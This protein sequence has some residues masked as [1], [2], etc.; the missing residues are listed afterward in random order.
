MA[1]RVII[2]DDDEFVSTSLKTILSAQDDI[3]VLG[4]A[5]NGPEAVELFQKEKPD[6]LLSDIQMPGGDGLEAAE[7]ILATDPEARIV[8]LT[9]FADDEYILRALKLG[10]KGYLIKQ[11]VG[12]IAPALRTVMAGQR[13]LGDETLQKIDQLMQ[14]AKDSKLPNRGPIAG[15]TEREM[16]IVE[17]IAQGLDNSQIA[18]SIFISE[19]TVRNHISTI[20]SKLGCKNRTQIAVYYYQHQG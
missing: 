19:G 11:E 5:S 9:S 1:I 20:L 10:A 4:T 15:L 17:L 7:Q 18:S 14:S 6:I 8:F 13:V 3:E 16:Q 2:V 12:T